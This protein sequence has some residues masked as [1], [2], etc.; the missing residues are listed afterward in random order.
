MD[1]IMPFKHNKERGTGQERGG[2]G[3]ETGGRR[4]AQAKGASWRRQV[5]ERRRARF[6]VGQA[7]GRGG[8]LKAAPKAGIC[9]EFR[10]RHLALL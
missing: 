4:S 10:G 5:K 3:T 6:S 2:T 1:G 7:G 8:W 9:T